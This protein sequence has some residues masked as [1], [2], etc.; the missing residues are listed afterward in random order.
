MDALFERGVYGAQ[1]GRAAAR[2][3]RLGRDHATARPAAVL[4]QRAPLLRLR[5]RPGAGAWKTCA[6]ACTRPSASRSTCAA[7]RPAS[8]RRPSWSTPPAAAASA[9]CTRTSTTTARPASRSTP[10]RW[11]SPGQFFCYVDPLD[12]AVAG[13]PCTLGGSG[14]ATF[15]DR[16]STAGRQGANCDH[17]RHPFAF[18]TSHLQHFLLPWSHRDIVSFSLTTEPGHRHFPIQRACTHQSSLIAL[19]PIRSCSI[20]LTAGSPCESCGHFP[21]QHGHH[22]A[23][24]VR[25]LCALVEAFQ[26]R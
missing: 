10:R 16:P 22:G 7:P 11:S 2:R 1:S 8:T 15:H 14:R 25:Y 26:K 4:R 17:S 23:Y 12:S 13:G 21:V 5:A 20:A 18:L 19:N 9:T 3:Q 6:P 24:F